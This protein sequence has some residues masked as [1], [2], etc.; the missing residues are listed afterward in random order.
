MFN[1]AQFE[2]P[3]MPHTVVQGSD[4]S[5]WYQMASGAGAAELYQPPQFTGDASEAAQ[6]ADMF[7]SM[8]EGTMLRTADDGVLE[9]NTPDGG[10]SMMYS[11]AHYDE[12]D[13]P[14]ETINSSDGMSWYAMQ[15]HA[16]APQFDSGGLTSE[17]DPGGTS[18]NDAAAVYNNAQFQS[19]MPGYEQ[20]I[21]SVNAQRAED[22][23]LEA[24]H[25]DGT[26]TAFYDKTMYQSPRGDYQVYEDARGGQWY[27]IQGTPAVE[28][29]PVYQDGKPVYDG[30]NLR[31]TAV[32]S[33]R[34]KATPQRFGEPEK[35]NPTDRKPP[36]RK[37]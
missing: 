8:Q 19:F 5:S 21:S 33:M 11:G 13:A 17:S 35:R 24:R 12:P 14:H 20:Q 34:Y 10:T 15:P 1:A 23:M 3:D 31:T 7:P 4:G 2:K 27:A 9:A 22:G 32:E 6:A 18:I 36:K 25:A 37:Q 30:E 26:G 29:R 16:E 28:R